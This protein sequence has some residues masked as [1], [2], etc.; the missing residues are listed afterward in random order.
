MLE[1]EFEH[2]KAELIGIAKAEGISLA[3]E[4]DDTLTYV[5]FPQAG[6]KFLKNRNNP[7]AFEPVPSV[8]TAAP[9]QAVSTG[10]DAGVY[11]VE[12]E[13][14]AYVVKVTEGGDVSQISASTAV[15]S[16]AP[17]AHR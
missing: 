6:L 11:T 8:E 15:T 1:P 17:V 16:P 7:D 5:L 14:Q 13:G 12:V 3:N 10:S 2:Q 9:A 4:V